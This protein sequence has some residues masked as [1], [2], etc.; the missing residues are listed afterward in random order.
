[1]GEESSTNITLTNDPTWIIDPI[2]GTTNYV[3]KVP[4]FA[5]S[6]AFCV[7]KETLIGV[8]YNPAQNEM[9]SALKGQGAYLNDKKIH[10]S[11]ETQVEVFSLSTNAGEST[12]FDGFF[13]YAGEKFSL[14]SRG[15]SI[16]PRIRRE[17]WKTIGQI[18]SRD[19]WVSSSFTTAVTQILFDFFAHRTRSFGSAALGLAYVARGIIDIYIAEGLKP[20]DLAAGALIIAEAGGS[21]LRINGAP[22]EPSQGNCIA[23]ATKLLTSR[24]LEIENSIL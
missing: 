13:S 7:N 8:V 22:Y 12:Y 24:V 14:L 3:H 15:F 5:I 2:D 18:Q 23:G 19:Y 10:T 17:K 21:V 9:Y 4:I 20:W 11:N 6:V 1:M 16:F